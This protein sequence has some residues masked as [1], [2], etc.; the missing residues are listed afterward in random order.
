M[1]KFDD[2]FSVKQYPY[3]QLFDPNVKPPTREQAEREGCILED[4]LAEAE[5]VL[6]EH[7]EAKAKR[8]SEINDYWAF[9]KAKH[10]GYDEKFIYPSVRKAVLQRAGYKC[11]V[12]GVSHI[13]SSLDMHHLR[14]F[15]EKGE[16]IRQK[17]TPE[18]LKAVC[19]RCHK[20]IHGH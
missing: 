8:E 15:D 3:W 4:I 5:Q 14:Y 6:R 1:N 9:E 20:R 13:D 18:D 11:E 19:R 16:S 7:K 10:F 12:C 2:F 17:E